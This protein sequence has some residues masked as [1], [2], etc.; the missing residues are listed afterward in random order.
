MLRWT[1]RIFVL[2]SLLICVLVSVAWLRSY[3]WHEVVTHHSQSEGETGW[4][5]TT[6]RIRQIEG[7]V[8]LAHISGTDALRP[9]IK[10]LGWSYDRYPIEP[11]APPDG[12][13]IAEMLGFQF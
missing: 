3:Q 9:P 5:T 2:G 1:G 7:V 11:A 12:Q 13:S 4:K 8:S 6:V 10:P